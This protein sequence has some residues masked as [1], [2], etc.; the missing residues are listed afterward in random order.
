ML[1]PLKQGYS[2]KAIKFNIVQEIKAGK[3]PRQAAAIAY[4]V[5]RKAALKAGNITKWAELLISS[6]KRK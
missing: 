5:A 2:N 3:S 1:V 4:S 6:R